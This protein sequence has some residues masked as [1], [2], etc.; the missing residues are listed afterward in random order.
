MI[1]CLGV[2]IVCI[3][4][5]SA[6]IWHECLS[7]ILPPSHL[8]LQ[9]DKFLLHMRTHTIGCTI[10]RKYLF[11]NNRNLKGIT[12]ITQQK[13]L[14]TYRFGSGNFRWRFRRNLIIIL[15]D[16]RASSNCFASF[17]FFHID[18]SCNYL[19]G[20]VSDVRLILQ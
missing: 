19:F 10:I 18:F 7:P 15:G 8:Y 6:L 17:N 3:H 14:Q 2:C 1:N 12:V 16:F 5:G 4:V 13:F 9:G 20:V 11:M